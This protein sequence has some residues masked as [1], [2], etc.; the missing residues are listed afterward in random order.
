MTLQ[1]Q[2]EK[3]SREIH[4]DGYAM[5][6]G[7]VASLYR[8]G[9]LDVHPEFQRI[10]RWNDGQKSRL[11]ESILLGIPIPSIFVSQRQN[12]IWDVVDGVQRLSTIFEF[13][14]IY[15]DE[16]RQMRAPLVLTKTEYL[17][18]LSG[19]TYKPNDE[20][21]NAFD[22]AMQ[23]DFKRARLDFRIVRKESDPDAQ[24]DL[25]QRLNSGTDLSAQEVRNC[26]LVMLNRPMFQWL[27]SLSEME[28][29]KKVV[30]ISDRK[31]NEA[32]RQELVL[33]FFSQQDLG[34]STSNL[35]EEHGEHL[36]DWMRKSATNW[37]EEY[38]QQKKEFFGQTFILIETAA[39]DDA[40]RRFES[41]QN[42]H[43]GPFS[44]SAY[45]FIT[46]GIAANLDSWRDDPEELSTKIKSIWSSSEFLDNSGTG[47]N[48]RRRVP[49]IV[50]A[51][52]AFFSTSA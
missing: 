31:E 34:T 5:S 52:R 14:G 33:R 8:D 44:I 16:N 21:E 10:F 15:R 49:R 46:S 40:F 18:D 12:G 45:E 6:I 9:D 38:L 43:L 24:Y 47:I 25:F 39:G 7:E 28:A 26:L 17:E 30:L 4:T 2:I 32:Y 36:T 29:F 1:E 23:R 51:A 3:R 48:T 37:S 13:L 42:R 20:G 19:Y 11:I 50:N 35:P 27:L 22:E 41:K